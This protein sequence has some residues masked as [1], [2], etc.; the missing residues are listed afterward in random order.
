MKYLISQEHKVEELWVCL[1]VSSERPGKGPLVF[2]VTNCDAICCHRPDWLTMIVVFPNC[3]ALCWFGPFTLGRF[4]L[5][6]RPDS[7]LIW[8]M[9][10]SVLFYKSQ[11]YNL[12]R[13]KL[14]VF[15]IFYVVNVLCSFFKVRL[16][17]PCM[18]FLDELLFWKWRSLFLVS[19]KHAQQIHV[20][21][22]PRDRIRS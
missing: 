10:L 12:K 15:F 2:Y 21:A 4:L 8:I 9:K 19:W 16:L 1:E 5:V 20:T 13:I 18:Y 14:L 17:K 7:C 6:I 3:T 11:T 22:S